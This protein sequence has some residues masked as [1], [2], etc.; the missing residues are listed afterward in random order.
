MI[1]KQILQIG[2]RFGTKAK[3]ANRKLLFGESGSYTGKRIFPSISKLPIKAPI[4]LPTKTTSMLPS[5]GRDILA[6]MTAQQAIE[7]MTSKTN[8]TEV[9]NQIQNKAVD[10]LSSKG[11][12]T[13]NY[14]NEKTSMIGDAISHRWQLRKEAKTKEKNDTA[15]RDL[16]IINNNREALEKEPSLAIKKKIKA[17]AW[18]IMLGQLK[19]RLKHMVSRLALFLQVA[20]PIYGLIRLLEIFWPRLRDFKARI[21][22]NWTYRTGYLLIKHGFVLKTSLIIIETVGIENIPELIAYVG[23]L[24]SALAPFFKFFIQDISADDVPDSNKGWFAR[25][26]ESANH[27]IN[28]EAVKELLVEKE[29]KEENSLRQKRNISVIEKKAELS[30][31]YNSYKSGE[32]DKNTYEN[33]KNE[34]NKNIVE[35][36]ATPIVSKDWVA[37]EN[38]KTEATK[39]LI[40]DTTEWRNA[41]NNAERQFDE[42]KFNDALNK[43][44]NDLVLQQHKA[45]QAAE[46]FA[47]IERDE[48]IKFKEEQ[49]KEG[50]AVTVEERNAREHISEGIGSALRNANLIYEENTESGTVY[51][52][53]LLHP[54][55]TIKKI[56]SSIHDKYVYVRDTGLGEIVEQKAHNLKV[57]SSERF[58]AIKEGIT[59]LPSDFR[60][61]WSKTSFRSPKEILTSFWRKDVE[62]KIEDP[63][64]PSKDLVIKTHDPI[65]TDKKLDTI[66]GNSNKNVVTTAAAAKI[67]EI[68]DLE[69]IK[70]AINLLENKNESKPSYSIPKVIYNPFSDEFDNTIEKDL[71]K[72]VLIGLEKELTD[73]NNQFR[74]ITYNPFDPNPIEETLPR[75]GK[76]PIVTTREQFDAIK[77]KNIVHNDISNN[78]NIMDDPNE[79]PLTSKDM[80]NPIVVSPEFAETHKHKRIFEPADPNTSSFEGTY[81]TG[82]NDMDSKINLSYQERRLIINSLEEQIK[83]EKRLLGS[84]T[85]PGLGSEEKLTNL[86]RDKVILE[87]LS[88]YEVEFDCVQNRLMSIHERREHLCTWLVEMYPNTYPGE[89]GEWNIDLEVLG[90]LEKR[91]L[92]RLSDVK[93]NTDTD[94][95]IS[96]VTEKPEKQVQIIKENAIAKVKEIQNYLQPKENALNRIAKNIAVMEQKQAIMLGKAIS[97]TPEET[98]T[99]N[100]LDKKVDLLRQKHILLATDIVE[101]RTN[102]NEA[103]SFVNA[104]EANKLKVNISYVEGKP[105]MNVLIKDDSNESGQANDSGIALKKNPIT[106]QEIVQKKMQMMVNDIKALPETSQEIVQMVKE[107]SALR[108]WF[109]KDPVQKGAKILAVGTTAMIGMGAA[110]MAAGPVAGLFAAG[111]AGAYLKNASKRGEESGRRKAVYTSLKDSIIYE[112][113]KKLGLPVQTHHPGLDLPANYV[114]GVKTGVVNEIVNDFDSVKDLTKLSFGAGYA[115]WRG[116]IVGGRAFCSQQIS[117]RVLEPL[118]EDFASKM[119]QYN[120]NNKK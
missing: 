49:L 55:E 44:E 106:M 64:I 23:I 90:A 9:T 42:R 78:N 70:E 27:R 63:L 43:Y 58:I 68:E 46:T 93:I 95:D 102:L 34:I 118:A 29:I 69:V 41:R 77:G 24:S 75:K 72:D 17:V 5:F 61:Q 31:L 99:Y 39:D 107:P 60:E 12:E 105:I 48:L 7:Y 101:K 89:Y 113:R 35:I 3:N 40:K 10:I 56:T 30:E 25:Y 109:A 45:E 103:L 20:M 8:V 1:I 83:Q 97:W 87:K 19:G 112:G 76:N 11:K 38:A 37:R 73:N 117:E 67:T 53:Y 28:G 84:D 57:N 120:D 13:S 71:H 33:S 47:K 104:A 18:H 85:N 94:T 52:H 79:A 15:V 110:F 21:W 81:T 59:S 50:G 16:A 66:V 2:L 32:I 22:S 111:Y 108:E 80:L 82:Q 115:L 36:K 54:I 114:S 14:L 98:D 100:N 86:V 92:S 51:K 119:T 65:I 6:G 62:V 74:P 4:N 26:K 91:E 96:F 88:L 116:G